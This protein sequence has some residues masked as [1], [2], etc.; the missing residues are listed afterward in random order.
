MEKG[1]WDRFIA[2]V[3]EGGEKNK[4]IVSI[5]KQ[6]KL[7]GSHEDVIQLQCVNAPMHK[8]LSNKVRDV[9]ILLHQFLKKV[10]TVELSIAEKKTKKTIEEP[11][12]QFKPNQDDILARA[13]IRP[14]F[15]F[16]NF[17]V[18][19]SNQVAYAASQAV[20][21]N[22]GSTY[23]P[24]FL[25]GG[26]GVGKTHLAQAVA[27]RIL[28][29]DPDKRVFFCPSDMFIN[30]LIESIR[31]RNT[32]RFRRKFR[33][34]NLL[35]VDDIQFIAGKQTMQ[36]EFFHTFNAIVSTGGQIILTSDVPPDQIK[37]LEDRLRSRF[38]GGLLVDVQ[39]PDFELRTAIILIKAKEKNIGL[40][41]DVAKIIA[42]YVTDTRGL[43][44]TLLTLYAKTLGVK[45]EI[46]LEIVE[47]YFQKKVKITQK[48][49]SYHDVIKTIC[50]FYNIKQVHIKSSDRSERYSFPRQ[51]AMYILR[52]HYKFRLEEI[53][54]ILKKKDHTTIIHGTE[55]I[56]QLMLKNPQTREDI[57]RIIQT[58]ESSP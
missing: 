14:K 51:V 36:E 54:D 12:L 25:Y 40:S 20:A 47:D 50:S 1:S 29:K 42:E 3:A 49:V 18:S 44:G 8:F 16:D 34:L 27:R 5:L 21:E 4:F 43:E 15:T 35:I 39:K 6:V 17:A 45:D 23:N 11:L 38:F 31:E 56:K 41:I 58:A 24:L 28:E 32:G 33:P 52:E 48:N 22:P 9:E 19:P 7:H 55:K 26:V 53:A 13:G 2:F 57:D 30:E 10:V 37:N 46:D